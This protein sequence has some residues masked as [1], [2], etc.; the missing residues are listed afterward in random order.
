MDYGPF[1]FLAREFHDGRMPRDQ[2][3]AEWGMAQRRQWI[4]AAWASSLARGKPG[5]YIGGKNG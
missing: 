5:K 4:Q 1:Y 2:F 3:I